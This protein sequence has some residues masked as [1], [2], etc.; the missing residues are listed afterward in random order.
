MPVFLVLPRIVPFSF[1]ET[2][3]AGI[4]TQVSCTVAE[5]D[6]PINI[7]WSLHGSNNLTALGITT[8]QV[9]PKVSVLVIETTALH[10]RGHYTC[11]ARNQAGSANY[12]ATLNINGNIFKGK[13][14]FQKKKK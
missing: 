5:G 11:T 7:S 1:E 2:I 9:S 13:I 6:P 14:N 10:N 3:Y 8:I 4:T 12:T